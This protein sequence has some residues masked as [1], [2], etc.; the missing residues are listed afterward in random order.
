MGR[1]NPPS[2][3]DELDKVVQRLGIQELLGL[4]KIQHAR[5]CVHS[6]TVFRPVVQEWALYWLVLG[7]PKAG[8]QYAIV[9]EPFEGTV[10]ALIPVSDGELKWMCKP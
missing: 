3:A 6:D 5:F 8:E 4:E 7:R 10:T 9:L 1:A 2:K